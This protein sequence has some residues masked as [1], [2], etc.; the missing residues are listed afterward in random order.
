MGLS[1]SKT[2]LN[3]LPFLKVAHRRS[4]QLLKILIDSGANKNIIAPGIL[5]NP[6]TVP[7]KSIKNIKGTTN[8]NR[9]GTI[10]FFNG[11]FKPLP[12]YELKFHYFFDGLIGPETLAKLNTH[13]DYENETITL[14]DKQFSY[15]KFFPA[16]QL[17]NHFVAIETK[18]NGDWFVPTFKN[19]AKEHSLNQDSI[20]QKTPKVL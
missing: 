17:Y 1:K 9:K 2:N 13:L 12:F 20:E 6:I 7:E 15:S 11:A 14:L 10:D 5:E 8:V 18:N 19:Y 16:N 4:K 3:Y